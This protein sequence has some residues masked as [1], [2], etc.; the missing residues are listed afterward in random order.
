[1]KAHAMQVMDEGENNCTNEASRQRERS[2]AT[3]TSVAVAKLLYLMTADLLNMYV[4]DVRRCQTCIPS[5]KKK[6]AMQQRK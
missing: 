4:L 2:G 5:N 6:N 3:E 1:M